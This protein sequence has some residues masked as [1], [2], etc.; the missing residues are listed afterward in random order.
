MFGNEGF[1][2]KVLI[3]AGSTILAFTKFRLKFSRA[4][5]ETAGSEGATAIFSCATI[6]VMNKTAAAIE[7]VATR[8][9]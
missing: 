5:S 9:W 2:E 3:V 6:F 7:H 8:Q 4:A 1:L